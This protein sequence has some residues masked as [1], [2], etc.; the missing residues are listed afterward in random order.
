MLG[1]KAGAILLGITFV[2][3]IAYA[4]FP[5]IVYSPLGEIVLV[6]MIVGAWHGGGPSAWK[7]I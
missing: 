4:I 7:L 2:A 1:G 3:F 5:E 6:M